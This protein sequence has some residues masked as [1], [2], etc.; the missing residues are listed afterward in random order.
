[1][2]MLFLYFSGTGNT[3]YVAHY[4]ARKLA[5]LPVEM[6]LRSMEWQPAEQVVDFDLLAS[7]CTPPHATPGAKLSDAHL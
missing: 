3:D 2:K 1:M 5:H 4:L 7:V 6:N